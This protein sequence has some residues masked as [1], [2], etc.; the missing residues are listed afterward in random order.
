MRRT[1]PP[2]YAEGAGALDPEAIA[3]VSAEAWPPMRD[4]EELHEALCGLSVLPALPHDHFTQLAASGRAAVFTI[5]GRRF[6]TA[7]ER[8]D[9]VRRGYPGARVETPLPAPPGGRARPD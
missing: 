8:S 7:A 3:Q 2:D 6:W 1:L 4:A 9:L 5:A